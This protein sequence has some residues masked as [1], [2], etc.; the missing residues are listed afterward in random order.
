MKFRLHKGFRY[1]SSLSLMFQFGRIHL[2]LQ[3][4][5]TKTNT[6]LAI[7]LDKL[8]YFHHNITK[9]YV[10]QFL[11]I[12]KAADDIPDE[13]PGLQARSQSKSGPSKKNLKF[14]SGAV[15]AETESLARY[16]QL[17]SFVICR[18]VIVPSGRIFIYCATQT[19]HCGCAPG[20]I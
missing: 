6:I 7:H 20:L 14:F 15:L 13:M 10:A 16:N 18:S 1:L 5:G 19:N 8:W 4:P 9:S 11:N 17:N 12:V 3:L 2:G